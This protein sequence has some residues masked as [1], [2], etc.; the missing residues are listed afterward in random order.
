MCF[1]TDDDDDD[2]VTGLCW[3]FSKAEKLTCHSRKS[4]VVTND[5]IDGS[6]LL[7]CPSVTACTIPGL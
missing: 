2:D 4:R 5:M 1:V 7:Q 6:V 3:P